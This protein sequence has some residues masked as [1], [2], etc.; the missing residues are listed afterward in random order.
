MQ[1]A[2]KEKWPK[3]DI[4]RDRFKRVRIWFKDRK[5]FNSIQ[6]KNKV[7]IPPKRINMSLALDSN[8]SQKITS[9]FK[10]LPI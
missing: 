9:T 3:I 7:D 5:S 2:I 4:N 8:A 6:D 1:I 10:L